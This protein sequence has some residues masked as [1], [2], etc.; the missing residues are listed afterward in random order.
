MFLS[1]WIYKQILLRFQF[2]VVLYCLCGF[3]C[4]YSPLMFEDNGCVLL[5]LMTIQLFPLEYSEHLKID[6]HCQ[7][8]GVCVVLKIL[9]SLLFYYVFKK[10][11]NL[12][13]SYVLTFLNFLLLLSFTGA[14]KHECDTGKKPTTNL[15]VVDFINIRY[16]EWNNFNRCE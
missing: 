10:Q 11:L 6:F 3:S 15:S 16:F 9:S 5:I 1:Y 8:F 14:V 4:A 13:W 12:T 2:H 7:Q